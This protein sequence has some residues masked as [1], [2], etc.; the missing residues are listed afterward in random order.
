V[1]DIEYGEVG[2]LENIID[3]NVNPLIQVLKGDKE[4]LI[5]FIDGLIQKVD[6]E[7]QEL[8]VAAPQGLIEMYLE[9]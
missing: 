1:V 6:R 5:P 7:K 8:H 9:A 3:N 4:M 2:V